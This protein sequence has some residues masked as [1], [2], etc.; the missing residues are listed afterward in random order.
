M[1]IIQWLLSLFLYTFPFAL[2]IRIWD[3]ILAH[4]SYYMFQVTIAILKLTKDDLLQ[5]DM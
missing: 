1:W 3:N 5:L 2:C 4:G